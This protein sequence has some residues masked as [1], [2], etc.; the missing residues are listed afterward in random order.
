MKRALTVTALLACAAPA[1]AKPAAEP[2]AELTNVGIDEKLEARLPLELELTDSSGAKVK[3]GQY[4]GKERPVIL[5]LNYSDCPMLC[6][7][8]LMG[9]V[10]GLKGVAWTAGEEFDVVTV[11]LDPKEPVS[12]SA[13]TKERYLEVY[14]RPEAA[15]GWHFLTADE[16]TIQAVAGSVGFKYEYVEERKEYAHAAA[17]MLA[18]P[19][20]RVARY[21]YGIEYPA[22]L[23]KMA[24]LEASRGEIGTTVDRIL[25]YC[26]HYDAK[27]GRYTPVAMNIMRV[28]AGAG[29]LALALVIAGLFFRERRRPETRGS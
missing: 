15:K 10:E 9:F 18:T 5:T 22:S 12:R 14:G 21:L 4:F 28:G 27:E 20:G 24:L 7:L 1:W 16:A 6:N 19:E 3:L 8:Q 11:S 2:I 25:L 29:G 26:F 17:L 23:L 13:R